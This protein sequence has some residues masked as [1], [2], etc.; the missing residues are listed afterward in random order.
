MTSEHVLI[1]DWCQQFPSHSQGNLFFGPEGALYASSGDGASFNGS[2]PDYGQLGGSL[3][4]TPTP[5]NPCGDPGGADPAPPTAEGGALRAQDLRTGGDPVTLDGS[6]IRVDPDTGAAW[7]DNANI[8]NND[9]NARRIIAYGLRNPYRFTIRPGTAEVWIGDVGFNTWEEIDT[10]SNPDA[11]PKDFGWPCYEGNATLPFYGGLGL[12][13]CDNLAPSD[14]TLPFYT[15]NHSAPIVSTDGCGVGSSSTSGLAF[16]SS[17]S[18]YPDSYD[19]ALFMTDYSR[20]CI[21]VFPE[22]GGQPNVSGPALFANLGERPVGEVNGGAVFLTTA[23]NGDLV[24][25]DY[26]RGEI[27]R[28]HYYGANVPP[29]ASFTATPSTGIAPLTVSFDASASS[30]AN[31][32]TLSFAWDL[33]GDGQYDDATGETTSRTYNSVGDVEVGLKV[34]DPLDASATTSRT[35]SAGNSPP[36]VHIDTP[37]ASLAWKVGDVISFSG[38]GSDPQDGTLPP[39]AYEW[40]LTIRHC[41][42]DCHSHIIQTFSAVK[43]GS[44]DA[45]DHEYPSHLL[46]SVTATDTGGLTATDE[47]EIYPLTGTVAAMTSPGG[48]PITVGATTE[49]LQPPRG[50]DIDRQMIVD[51][52]HLL[53][54]I[55]T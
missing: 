4:N 44:F 52:R 35:V 15:Y 34:T 9:P 19:G 24:Y 46:L 27:R 20:N 49:V 26:D 5:T 54:G 37:L 51:L 23:P 7:P 43:T 13:I 48:I 8:G 36:S 53:R 6:L 18:G 40:T 30:D 14:V 42:S 31:G 21:W 1:E 25:V 17:T 12:A 29:V 10:L 32:D 28:V 38:S 55:G 39:S 41:P 16:L 3:L 22:S 33:D 2:T 11:A 50:K 45:P 47:V